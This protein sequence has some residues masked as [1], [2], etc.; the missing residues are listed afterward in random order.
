MS[1]YDSWIKKKFRRFSRK[2]FYHSSNTR[3]GEEFFFFFSKVQTDKEAMVRRLMIHNWWAV[4]NTRDLLIS[5][6]LPPRS[7]RRKLFIAKP[8]PKFPFSSLTSSSSLSVEW[9]SFPSLP[10]F[11]PNAFPYIIGYIYFKFVT[12]IL[13]F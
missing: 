6:F 5:A 7:T 10:N 4:H 8:K 2:L 12:M 9:L 1:Q 11:H 3:L 13:L